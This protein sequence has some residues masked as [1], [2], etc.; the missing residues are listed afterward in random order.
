MKHIPD[1]ERSAVELVHSLPNNTVII[2]GHIDGAKYHS[3]LRG[4]EIRNA[5][6]EASVLRNHYEH[7]SEDDK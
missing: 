2:M 4:A 1:Y 7:D 3:I 5:S 6:E